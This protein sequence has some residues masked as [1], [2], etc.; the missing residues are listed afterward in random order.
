MCL[1]ERAAGCVGA[2]QVLCPLPTALFLGAWWEPRGH[3]QGWGSAG[4]SAGCPL[5][6]GEAL[7]PG[8]GHSGRHVTRL[9]ALPRPDAQR[10]SS[11]ALPWAAG[12]VRGRPWARERGVRLRRPGVQVSRPSVWAPKVGGPRGTGKWGSTAL[13]LLLGC[14]F[15]ETHRTAGCVSVQVEPEFHEPSSVREQGKFLRHWITLKLKALGHGN[16]P[17]ADGSLTGSG[18]DWGFPVFG[19]PDAGRPGGQRACRPCP[20]RWR[21][22]CS[23][24]GLLTR[25][26]LCHH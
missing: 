23:P 4:H 19:V 7:R 17:R 9:C 16:V 6:A 14:C 10:L 1:W 8:L 20:G 5:V 12:P 24:W 25:V 11:A 15:K 13:N 26:P 21:A 18:P 3:D 22:P 2:K